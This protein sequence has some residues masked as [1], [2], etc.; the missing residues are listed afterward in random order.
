MYPTEDRWFERLDLLFGSFVQGQYDE[1]LVG[2]TDDLVLN[3]RGSARLATIVPRDQI[4]EWH[5]STQQLAGGAFR[6][7]VCF[8]LVRECVGIVVLTHMIDRHGVTFRYESVNHCTLRGDLLAAWFSYPMNAADYAE[9]WDLR[10][11]AD[12]LLAS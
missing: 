8:I 6:S 1:F 10:H 9:A 12:P 3:V 2:C 11:A 7:S 4:S 5:R